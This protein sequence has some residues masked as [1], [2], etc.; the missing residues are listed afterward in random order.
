MTPSAA[1]DT[2][3]IIDDLNATPGFGYASGN[4]VQLND[5]P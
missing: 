5:C 2:A 4:S 1:S 3:T